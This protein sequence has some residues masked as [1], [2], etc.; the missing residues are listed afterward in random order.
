MKVTFENNIP[1]NI[2]DCCGGKMIG[3][4]ALIS[5]SVQLNDCEY[6]L[7]EDQTTVRKDINMG[8]CA[9]CYQKVLSCVLRL[10]EEY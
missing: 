3:I 1:V 9:K 7:T 5:H 8:L 10:K 4:D 6:S 2:C